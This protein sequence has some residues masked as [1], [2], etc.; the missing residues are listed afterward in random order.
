M[1]FHNYS[2]TSI[3]GIAEPQVSNLSP[4]AAAAQS[5]EEDPETRCSYPSKRCDNPRSLKVG[6]TLHRFCEYHREKANS[7]QRRLQQRRKARELGEE[8]LEENAAPLEMY[9]RQ[10]QAQH[11]LRQGAHD[12]HGYAHPPLHVNTPPPET[13]AVPRLDIEDEDL[14]M[15]A[16]VLCVDEDIEKDDDSADDYNMGGMHI[17]LP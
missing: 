6:G 12:F 17:G 10:L 4:S 11:Q 9:L 16:T 15:L 2:E 13:R 8:L 3:A 1:S 5:Q 14:Q 7:N